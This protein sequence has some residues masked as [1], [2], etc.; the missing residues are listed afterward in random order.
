MISAFAARSP[1]LTPDTVFFIGNGVLRVAPVTAGGSGREQPMGPSWAEYMDLL[2]SFVNVPPESSGFLALEDFSRLPAPRQAE[3]FDREFRAI[4]GTTIDVAA[5]R[6]HL[7]GRILHRDS[8]ILSNPL[9]REL[10]RLIALTA[11]QPA[12]RTHGVD[13][14]TTNVDCALEQNIASAIDS[15]GI[16]PDWPGASN[17]QDDLSFRHATIETIVDF[18]LSARWER[19][20]GG[21]AREI[22]EIRGLRVRLWKLHGCLRDLKIRISRDVNMTRAVLDLTGDAEIG[23]CGHVPTDQLAADLSSHWRQTFT[24]AAQTRG[25]SGTFSQTE[26]FNNLLMLAQQGPATDYRPDIR[27]VSDDEQRRRLA[28]FRDLLES[29]PIIFV[30]YSIPEV[31]VDVVYALQQYPQRDGQVKRWQLSEQREQSASGDERLRQMGIDPWPFEVP[32][33]G[34]A[35]IPGKLRAA[36]RHEWRST[37]SDPLGLSPDKDWRKALQRV[38]GQ[39]WLE[40]QLDALSSLAPAGEAEK[41]EL[42]AG[43]HPRLVV[44][45]LGSIWHGFALTKTEDFPVQRRVSARL[46]SV[47]AQVPGGSGLVPIMVAAAAAGP[48]AAGSLAFISNVPKMWGGWSEIEDFCLSAGIAVYPWK[49]GP[50]DDEHG[51]EAVGRT[52]HVIFFDPAKSAGGSNDP[53]QRFI[54]DV[55]A[56]ANESLAPHV[57][58]WASVKVPPARLPVGFQVLGNEDFLFI[59]KESDPQIITEWR[60]P[61][62]YETGASGDELVTRLPEA[63][64]KPT[65]WTAGVGSF[66]RT[67]V[68]LAGRVPDETAYSRG[69]EGVLD[70]IEEDPR[71]TV[72]ARCGDLRE[73][74]LAKLIS[75]GRPGIW[76][77]G[78]V[79]GFTYQD[80]LEYGIWLRERWPDLEP[81]IWSLLRTDID[82]VLSRPDPRIGGGMLTTIHEG[83]LMALW[84]W[85]D[86]RTENIAVRISTSH[87][88]EDQENLVV[89]C[90][91]LAADENETLD[92]VVIHVN[93]SE[94]AISTGELKETFGSTDPIRRNTLA[95]GDTVR[96]ILAYGLWTAAYRQD[97]G[98]P[99]SIARI[100]LTSAALATLKCYVGSFVDFLK[101]LERLRGSSTWVAMW[102]FE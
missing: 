27:A 32:A 36:R 79:E 68:A 1:V 4:T 12:S 5:L 87:S 77:F 85:R 88:D 2:W 52:S 19:S 64:A 3:W 81:S 15:L 82:G 43:G 28:D 83:G 74:Y 76:E 53:R 10:G 41:T 59:D 47:D 72:F 78:D 80:E 98:V 22:R 69:P 94:L 65:I 45:G 6:L 100:L 11:N 31:D 63:G 75:F 13:V 71:L 24:P 58:D 95:A 30:G 14:I 46:I 51:A 67:M 66:V 8:S 21:P 55:Q 49:P 38:A 84:R 93:R 37:P 101:L 97:A 70:Y 73:R 17:P 48:V 35:S 34:F 86:K 89:T 61:T 90:D 16:G 96:G 99:V 56:L 42:S 25:H 18:R 44:A 23:L 9:L 92:P 39:A 26:Y 40:P 102:G 33:V 91:V 62:V 50:D 29:R 60:G 57:T 20:A 7:L 54:M